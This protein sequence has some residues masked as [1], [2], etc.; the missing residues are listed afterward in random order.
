[1]FI[2]TSSNNHG[3]IVF[4]SFERTDII[5]FSNITFYYNRF[6]AGDVKAIGRFRTQLLL[7]DY[8]WST[9][10]N[11][12]ENDRYSNSSTVWT[13]LCLSFTVETYG[14]KIIHDEFDRVLAD[15]CFGNIKRTQ[16]VD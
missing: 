7:K 15:M 12:P 13:L 5:Q 16:S 8:T 1:M 11:I 10:F 14:I 9:R 4:C 3:P 2:E 6:S